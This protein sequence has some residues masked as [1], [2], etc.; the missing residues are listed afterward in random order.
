MKR[1]KESV[2]AAAVTFVAALIILVLLFTLSLRHD[3]E[4]LAEASIPELQDEEPIYLDPEMLQIDMTGDEN[5]QDID[6]PAPQPPGEPDLA[7]EPSE[8]LHV[9]APEKPEKP[10]SNKPE[11]VADNKPS[12][13]KTSKPEPTEDE[14]RVAKA[15]ESFKK[16][17][18]NGSRTGRETAFSGSGGNGVG[19]SGNIGRKLL[20]ASTWPVKI[21]Q[22]K[23][24]VSVNV[25]VDADGNVTKAT[26]VS[27]GTPN[28]RK[29]VEKMAK[30]FKW[31]K[32]AGAKPVSGTITFT[33][34]L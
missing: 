30:G 2:I 22:K 3:R 17:Q 21:T 16:S 12:E 31:S 1:E 13:V 24:T 27:G 8:E 10:V 15:A 33:I 26:A 25:T 9:K 14:K 11:L 23:V 7:P 29:E 28:L 18:N 20:S 32:E 19:Y 6:E 4:A 34:S 5:S